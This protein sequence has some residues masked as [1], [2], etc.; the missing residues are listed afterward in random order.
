MVQQLSGTFNSS[1]IKGKD[2]LDFDR[3]QL[4]ILFTYKKASVNSIS[5]HISKRLDCGIAMAHL[6][7]G[8]AH[9]GATCQWELLTGLEVARFKPV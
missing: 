4:E 9:E 7:I 6:E 2:F 1:Q 8:A 5:Y 3:A